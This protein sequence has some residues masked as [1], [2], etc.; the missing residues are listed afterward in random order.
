MVRASISG[1]IALGL[2]VGLTF[3]M[4]R[5]LPRLALSD[6]RLG[7]HSTDL[8]ALIGTLFTGGLLFSIVFA[9]ALFTGGIEIT[10]LGL[11]AS[12][13]ISIILGIF[14]GTALNAAW[15]EYTFRGWPFSICV[16]AF[17]PHWVS[18]GLGSL[19]G[20]AHILNPN[21]TLAAILSVAVAGYLIS[22]TMLASRKIASPIGLHIGWN[23]VQS[24]LTTKQLWVMK[25][26]PDS[27]L[28]GGKFGLEAST[29]GIF[30]TLIAAIIA[31]ILYRRVAWRLK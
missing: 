27:S 2:T 17:G 30:V 18:W 8:P 15:E 29:A 3:G 14:V 26:H 9:V 31:F 16:K 21:W 6:L 7:I 1:A 5:L 13:V 11:S 22:Y 10:W 4:Q 25:Y 19:F 20:V 28:S 23:F 12:Q 24:V